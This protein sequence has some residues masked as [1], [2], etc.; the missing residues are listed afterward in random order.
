MKLSTA[1]AMI[2]FLMGCVLPRLI[3]CGA[4][5]NGQDNA[6]LTDL[7]SA[8]QLDRKGEYGEALQK[9]RALLSKP[10][11]QLTPLLHPYILKQVA[12]VDN[13]LGDYAGA[14]VNVRE[15]LR[16]LVAAHETNTATCATAEG[17]LANALE[18]EGNYSEAENVAERA[19]S[20]GRA[21]LSPQAPSFAILLT[22]LGHALE[23]EGK[24]GRALKLYQDAL[25]IMK[26]AGEGYRIELGTAYANLAGAYLARGNAK[27]A[28]EL[29]SLA[30][31]TWKQVL[32]SDNTFTVY[33]VSLEVLS[34]EKLKRYGTAEALIPEMLEM[35][36]SGL[37]VSHPDRA[38]LLDVAASVYIAEKKYPEAARVLQ[39]AVE[40]TKRTS[41]AGNPLSRI[42]LANYSYVL[43]KMGRTE[44]A[45][46]VRAENGILLAFPAQ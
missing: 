7:Q 36:V 39:E 28:L 2:A 25:D 9:Y 35:G 3:A 15:A 17:V 30:F 31:A 12:D 21:T 37:G 18:G 11:V 38:R 27:K 44:E 5:A 14:E 16:L 19:V 43:A 6:A 42:V 34:Y 1:L 45:S 40:L 8:L 26:N 22:L 24:R 10:S 4:Q 20:A 46:Q 13:G 29:I 41:P 32:P 23:A 33:A